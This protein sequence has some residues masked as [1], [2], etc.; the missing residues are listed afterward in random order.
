M[1][2]AVANEVAIGGRES[3]TWSRIFAEAPKIVGKR[4]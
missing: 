3:E 2:N 1:D 4:I